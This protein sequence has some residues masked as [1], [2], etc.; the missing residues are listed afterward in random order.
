MEL[1]LHLNVQTV[2]QLNLVKQYL[3]V[4]VHLMSSIRCP[5]AYPLHHCA[6]LH[7]PTNLKLTLLPLHMPNTT[8]LAIHQL[9]VESRFDDLKQLC[10][11]F[12]RAI[13]VPKDL[14]FPIFYSKLHLLSKN[15]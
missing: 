1:P 15:K 9:S 11:A 13:S 2:H 10:T 7:Q 14:S 6:D 5:P 12:I 8:R 3:T 4:L